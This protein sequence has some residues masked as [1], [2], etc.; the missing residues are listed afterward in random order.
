MVCIV[1]NIGYLSTKADMRVDDK[2]CDCWEKSKW[3]ELI[4][5]TSLTNVV[6]TLL[7]KLTLRPPV[8]TF[9]FCFSRCSCS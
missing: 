7:N 2:S 1:C 5:L 9:L 3:L 6:Q 8:T 4:Q